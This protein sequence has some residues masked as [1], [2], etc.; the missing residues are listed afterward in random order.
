MRDESEKVWTEDRKVGDT[1]KF[2]YDRLLALIPNDVSFKR[3]DLSSKNQ[4]M[5]EMQSSGIK[6]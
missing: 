3:S 6:C 4:K 2:D 1:F 5:K